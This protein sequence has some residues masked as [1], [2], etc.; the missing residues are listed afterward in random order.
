MKNKK[1]RHWHDEAV[2]ERGA[3]VAM[4]PGIK[5]RASEDEG[6]WGLSCWYYQE[7]V[8]I[9]YRQEGWSGEIRKVLKDGVDMCTGSKIGVHVAVYDWCS[10]FMPAFVFSWSESSEDFESIS[11]NQ[12]GT[13]T[14]KPK[15][16]ENPIADP[17]CQTLPLS[18]FFEWSQAIAF[19]LLHAWFSSFLAQWKCAWMHPTCPDTTAR[20]LIIEGLYSV[21]N[22][23]PCW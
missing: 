18:F 15:W 6:S 14:L 23:L 21:L 17:C 20:C 22:M 19:V 13:R 5:Q 1:T 9:L 4:G 7:S 11:R 16:A 3:K 10:C 8:G 12:K 2:G